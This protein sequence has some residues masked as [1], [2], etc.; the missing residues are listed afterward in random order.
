MRR[1][2]MAAICAGTLAVVPA[3]AACGGDNGDNESAAPPAASPPSSSSQTVD[4]SATEFEFD[5][6]TVT[7]DAP[8]TVTIHLTNDG[9]VG[10]AIE[11]EGNGVEEET[12]TIGPGESADVTVDL[13]AGDYEIY[14]PVDGH[15]DQGM[16]GTLTVNG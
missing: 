7:V 10:H 2:A 5:P 6:S 8:G 9:T 3:L 16:E 1:T 4:I 15:R 11:I 13:T 14:C 12:E